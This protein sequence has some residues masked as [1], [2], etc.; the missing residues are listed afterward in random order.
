MYNLTESLLAIFHDPQVTFCQMKGSLLVFTQRNLI[1]IC[2][3]RKKIQYIP[4]RLL[5]E[6]PRWLLQRGRTAEAKD[7]FTKIATKNRKPVPNMDF[8]DSI[9]SDKETISRHSYTYMDLFRNKVI[10]RRSI[11][12]SINWYE[13]TLILKKNI[14]TF[15]FGVFTRSSALSLARVEP[16]QR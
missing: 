14:V 5:P 16:T 10:L 9:C 15:R 3:K 6:S 12:S 8:L 11:I 7:I 1:S 4:Y 13:S 2:S